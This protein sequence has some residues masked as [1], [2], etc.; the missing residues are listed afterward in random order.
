[1]VWLKLV[2]RQRQEEHAL[3]GHTREL[4]LCSGNDGSRRG[5]LGREMTWPDQPFKS[6]LRQHGKDD[7]RTKMEVK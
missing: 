1:M 4:G 6:L 3:K 5:E 7:L 2:R